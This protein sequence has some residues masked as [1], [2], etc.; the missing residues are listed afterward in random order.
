MAEAPMTTPAVTLTAEQVREIV[1][2]LAEALCD[3]AQIIRKHI[4][5]G[6]LGYNAD[7]DLA[8]SH[9]TRTW[10]N[11]DE[12]LHYMDQALDKARAA[13]LLEDAP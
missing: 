12:H 2:D 1:I 3:A 10:A 7:G 9:L 8:E 5:I 11:L 13:G 6:A 4:P